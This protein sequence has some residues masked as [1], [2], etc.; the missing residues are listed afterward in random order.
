MNPKSGN[1]F[2]H[3]DDKGWKSNGLILQ[4]PKLRHRAGVSVL[5][6]NVSEVFKCAHTS[7]SAQTGGRIVGAPAYRNFKVAAYDP[8]TQVQ[9]GGVLVG[10]PIRNP[11]GQSGGGLLPYRYFKSL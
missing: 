8:V 5:D 1:P 3:C 11:L 2:A 6:H 10:A 7:T 9:A 4:D